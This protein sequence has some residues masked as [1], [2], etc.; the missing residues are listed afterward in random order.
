M[1]GVKRASVVIPTWNGAHHLRTCL[2]SLEAQSERSFETILVDGGST[3]GTC[4]LLESEFPDIARSAI[5]LP[6]NRGFAA[7]V[8]A[9]IRSSTAN[10]IVLLNNDTEAEPDWLAELLKAFD[11][12]ERIGLVTSKVMLF[13]N[14]AALHTTGDQ[15]L[16]NGNASNRGA[17]E[18]D[19]GQYD[20]LTDVFGASGAAMAARRALFEDIGLFEE[21]F[22]SY[23]ED[24]DLAWRARLRGWRCVYVPRAVVYHR[25]SA[26]GGG[27]YASY[28]V[29]RNRIWVIARNMPR[30]LLRRHAPEI[31]CAQ[32]NHMIAALRSWRGAEARATLRGL[33][34]GMLTWPLMLPARRSIQGRRSVSDETVEAL[35]TQ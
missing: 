9:G 4:E 6:F 2:H 21:A 27:S 14:R 35:L 12:D 7:A 3:D 25:L 34:V 5:W 29:A 24:V 17:W 10:N 11:A 13:D 32:A 8:N 30:G 20:A 31:L 26:T 19:L 18:V 23:M 15:V 16:K 22:E 28:R 33:V 1:A